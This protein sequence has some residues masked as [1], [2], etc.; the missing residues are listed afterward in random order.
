MSTFLV[1]K[2]KS[3]TEQE[4]TYTFCLRR[5]FSLGCRQAGR[6]I[7]K[8]ADNREWVLEQMVQGGTRSE[9]KQDLIHLNLGGAN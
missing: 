4:A 8:P 3:D 9:K 2:L 5:E 7:H 1:R 6:E